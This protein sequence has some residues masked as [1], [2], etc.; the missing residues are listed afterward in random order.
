MRAREVAELFHTHHCRLAIARDDHLDS[1]VSLST[2]K[3][4]TVVAHQSVQTLTAQTHQCDTEVLAGVAL[5]QKRTLPGGKWSA[6][7][8][9]SEFPV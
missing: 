3:H 4:H 8:L 2:C 5:T 7:D 6:N 9:C 1:S